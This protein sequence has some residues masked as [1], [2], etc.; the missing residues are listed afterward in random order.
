MLMMMMMTSLTVQDHHLLNTSQH[1]S[2]TS[3]NIPQ[4]LSTSLNIS[5]HTSTSLNIP[6]HLST[7]LNISQHPPYSKI[8]Q[9]KQHTTITKYA[10]TFCRHCQQ[11]KF[12]TKRVITVA[13]A[14]PGGTVEKHIHIQLTFV[15]CCI[16]GF[17]S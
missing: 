4:H 13:F 7:Y 8:V 6:Q 14:A 3:L 5:Q 10:K 1:P 9:K 2:T 15:D 16:C 12:D 11:Q 17:L